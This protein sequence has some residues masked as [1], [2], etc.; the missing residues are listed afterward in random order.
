MKCIILAGGFATRL[1]PITI[2]QAKALLE[3]KGKPLISHIVEKVPPGIDILVSCNRKFEADFRRWQQSLDRP[4]EIGVEEVWTEEQKKGACGSL[5]YWV[6]RQSITE[7]LMVLASDNYFDFDLAGFV[8]GYDG[9]HPLVAVYDLGDISRATEFGV[10]SLKGK[11]IIR[12]TEKPA[13]PES[14]LVATACY[15]LPPRVLLL[16]SDFCASGKKDNLGGFIA[17][18]VSRME[19]HAYTFSG[20]WVDIGSADNLA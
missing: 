19:V 2:N 6:R 1:Y 18:L 3:Y 10:V 12:F 15:L 7:D 20:F 9:E 5:E 11:C 16:L 8:A 13:R 14:S 4:V 17:Y